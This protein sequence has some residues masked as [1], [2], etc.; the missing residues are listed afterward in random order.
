MCSSG[1]RKNLE[2]ALRKAKIKRPQRRRDSDLAN[3]IAR[4]SAGLDN[5]EVVQQRLISINEDP[6]AEALEAEISEKTA[7]FG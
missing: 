6:E 1:P 5:A 3:K 4:R 2:L 7:P